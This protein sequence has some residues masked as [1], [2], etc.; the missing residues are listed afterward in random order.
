MRVAV[1]MTLEWCLRAGIWHLCRT[2]RAKESGRFGHTAAGVLILAGLGLLRKSTCPASESESIL[3]R[4]GINA[5]CAP[6]RSS[7]KLERERERALSKDN[8]FSFSGRLL[9]KEGPARVRRRVAC[10]VW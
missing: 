8:G 1:P 5:P 3:Q 9:Y 7:V 2:G 6:L 4:G 10:Y